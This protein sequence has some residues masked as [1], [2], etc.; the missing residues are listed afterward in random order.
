[1]NQL[2]MRVGGFESGDRLRI[3]GSSTW[4]RIPPKNGILLRSEDLFPDNFS[5]VGLRA[6]T[7]ASLS[8]LSMEALDLT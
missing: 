5:E 4:G 8:R 3:A 6:A 7:E 1:M 2:E